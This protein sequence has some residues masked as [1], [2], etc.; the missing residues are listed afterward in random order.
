MGRPDQGD[1]CSEFEK[2]CYI[3]EDIVMT[4]EPFRSVT[5]A[6]GDLRMELRKRNLYLK[7]SRV[8]GGNNVIADGL[9]RETP[10]N[11]EWE[12]H[13]LDWAQIQSKFPQLQVKH[14]FSR[15]LGI[16]QSVGI[17]GSFLRWTSSQ[18]P[19][20]GSW[21]SSYARSNTRKRRG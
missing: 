12:I 19:S 2:F 3:L 16:F 14:L 15:Y 6:I 17:H 5:S 1:H 21:S 13:P 18:L 10:L 8:P 7:A 20:T 11:S 9:S 4:L